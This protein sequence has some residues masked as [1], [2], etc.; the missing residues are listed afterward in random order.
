[1]TVHGDIADIATAERVIAA[2]MERF[3]R[4]DTLINN[5]VDVADAGEGRSPFV[6]GRAGSGLL[7][8]WMSLWPGGSGRP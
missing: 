4:I 1:M 8:L 6:G 3:G 2:G 5:A 7:A